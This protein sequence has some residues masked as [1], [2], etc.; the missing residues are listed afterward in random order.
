MDAESFSLHTFEAL[1]SQSMENLAAAG[2]RGHHQMLPVPK[3][4]PFFNASFD[5]HP[6]SAGPGAPSQH[7]MMM[8]IGRETALD[9]GYYTDRG[10]LSDHRESRSFRE[11][12]PIARS[13]VRSGWRKGNY[14]PFVAVH[15]KDKPV[16]GYLSSFC[17]WTLSLPNMPTM[18]GL[19]ASICLLTLAP[20]VPDKGPSLFPR[21]PKNSSTSRLQFPGN[22]SK[23]PAWCNVAKPSA[24]DAAS[25]IAVGTASVTRTTKVA[26]PAASRLGRAPTSC[27]N[28]AAIQEHTP[29]RAMAAKT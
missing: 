28:V 21:P 12:R 4:G 8:G 27:R 17:A 7:G 22:R 23:Y 14:E 2:N 10:Y 13:G 1:I 18:N 15:L 19:M 5:N 16:S 3:S 29:G 24:P 25:S 26:F 9:R 11:R 6:M 20:F